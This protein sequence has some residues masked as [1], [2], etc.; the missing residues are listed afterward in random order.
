MTSGKLEPTECDLVIAGAGLVGATLACYL[1]QKQPD[2]R[3]VLLDAAPAPATYSGEQFDPRVVALSPGS[4]E[5]LEYLNVWPKISAMRACPYRAMQVWDGEGTGSIQFNSEQLHQPVLGH[6]VENSVAVAALHQRLQEELAATGVRCKF[7]HRLQNFAVPDAATS[8]EPVTVELD[9][10]ETLHTRLLVAADG[11]T[12]TIRAMAGFRTRAWDYGHSAIVT[13]VRT[14]RSHEFTA[15]QRFQTSGPLAFLPLQVSPTGAAK[16]TAESCYS[17]IV[18]S[19]VTE[20][21]DELM[22]LD[23]ESFCQRLGN[24]FEH[25]L[26]RVL[27]ADQRHA[28]PLQQRH[29]VRYWQPRVALVGDAAHSLH[30]LAGQGVN[31]GLRDAKVLGEEILRA[32]Q[33]KVFLGDCSILKRYER[34]RQVHN[35]AAMATME[36][37]KR[38]FAAEAPGV[39]WLRNAGMTF[40]NEQAWLK[41]RLAAIAT[42]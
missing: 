10:G 4:Q 30:P 2:L 40:V 8:R 12:S 29:A 34:R 22:A 27:H 23:D 20:E 39:R 11:A 32:C 17:S 1:S 41:K 15:W 14:E 19:I 36:S 31:L 6:I 3:I 24:A 9:N 5:L 18:W 35:M 28:I 37:F 33:R 13:T 42:E 25:R 21:A 7:G 26:G 38:L 16:S